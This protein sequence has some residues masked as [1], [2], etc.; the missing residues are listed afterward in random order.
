ML[1]QVTPTSANISYRSYQQC[2]YGWIIYM[3]ILTKI[4]KPADLTWASKLSCEGVAHLTLAYNVKAAAVEHNQQMTCSSSSEFSV[5]LYYLKEWCEDQVS[6]WTL[7]ALQANGKGAH[8]VTLRLTPSLT[9]CMPLLF[10]TSSWQML[11]WSGHEKLNHFQLVQWKGLVP[12]E[13]R[14]R[15]NCVVLNQQLLL[16]IYS[17]RVCSY[18]LLRGVMD[19]NISNIFIICFLPRRTHY[20]YIQCRSSEVSVSLW[21]TVES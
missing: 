3:N 7:T 19:S 10:S 12:Q 21:Y 2:Q 11:L 13:A 1:K 15:G 20:N 18:H 4:F 9:H 16:A 17:C 8:T 14:G 5:Y 6:L